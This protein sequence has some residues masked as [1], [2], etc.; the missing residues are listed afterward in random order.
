[1]I[2]ESVIEGRR[3]GLKAG[4]VEADDIDAAALQAEVLAG[5]WDWIVLR[6][7]CGRERSIEALRPLGLEPQQ[8]DTLMTWSIALA[9]CAVAMPTGLQLDIAG[10]DDGPAIRALVQQVF[11]RYPNHYTANPL[12]DSRLALEGYVEWALSH[13]GHPQRLCWVVRADQGIAALSCSQHDDSGTATGVLHGVHPAHAGR[14][15]YRGLIEA[16]LAHYRGAGCAR[17]RIATQAG[18]HTVQNLWARLGLRI[19]SSRSTVH[20]MPLLG[21]VLAQPAHPLGQADALQALLDFDA[22]F[23][24]RPALRRSLY[25]ANA[26]E[27]AGGTRLGAL[28]WPCSLGRLRQLSL[29]TDAADRPLAWLHS[30]L[31]A[32]PA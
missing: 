2:T 15:L 27:L 10:P 12:L 11:Q 25:R 22:A 4:R 24:P 26:G 30:D 28:H 31:L 20:L 5:G 19:E 32:V 7:P 18:N 21:R 6:L 9:D 3:F 8:T 23:A 16:S 17:F 1:M 14:G 13:I 29:L